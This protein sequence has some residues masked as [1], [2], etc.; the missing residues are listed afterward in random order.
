MTCEIPDDYRLQAVERTG[1]P[2]DCDDT[3]IVCPYCGEE[4]YDQHDIYRQDGRDIG[5]IRCITKGG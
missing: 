2:G 4:Y 3:S 1:Y 5:C